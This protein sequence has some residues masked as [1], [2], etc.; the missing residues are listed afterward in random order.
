MC[1]DSALLVPWH[2]FQENCQ[3][4]HFIFRFRIAVWCVQTESATTKEAAA[5]SAQRKET[6]SICNTGRK[7]WL[8]PAVKSFES[9][10]WFLLQS[11]F[12]FFGLRV[13][14]SSHVGA[15]TLRT[16]RSRNCPGYMWNI[17]FPYFPFNMA[18]I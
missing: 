8:V 11:L 1:L 13:L 14:H 9:P 3:S 12:L 17:P 5:L 16:L 6:C 10:S 18:V 15:L 2:F 4:V 7:D